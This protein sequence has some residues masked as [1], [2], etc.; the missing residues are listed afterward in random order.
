MND[1]PKSADLGPER[2]HSNDFL[3]KLYRELRKLAESKLSRETPNQTLTP[4][5][6]VHEVYL[7][8]AGPNGENKE[9]ES[10]SHFWG[11]AARA[12]RCILV[13]VARKK[14]R[15][16]AANA[17]IKYDLDLVTLNFD[18]DENHRQ[19]LLQVDE[20]MA[21]LAKNYPDE[22][23]MIEMRFFAGLTM[24]EVA[25]IQGI[26]R[27][28]AQRRWAFAKAQLQLMMTA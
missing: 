3:T 6:L 24:E 8:L 4:T 19:L 11:S 26:S 21:T 1:Q 12:M 17:S 15:R 2:T 23:A 25:E 14:H 5:E 28:T 20:C 9:W 18:M 27:R 22:A 16:R 10:T 7:K 13:D